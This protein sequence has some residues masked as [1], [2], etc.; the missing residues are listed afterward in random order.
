MLLAA[1]VVGPLLPQVC[2][3]TVSMCK[4]RKLFKFVSYFQHIGQDSH[5]LGWLL[6]FPG[7]S[8]NVQGFSDMASI[9][10][11]KWGEACC[12]LR[13]LSVGEEEEWK[14]LVPVSTCTFDKLAQHSLQ[15]FV[16]PLNHAV[17]LRMIWGGSYTLDTQQVIDFFQKL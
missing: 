15:G 5:L 17:N 4:F 9:E 8:Q 3:F 2:L 11:I 12:R 1:L 6:S 14:P 13:Y 7:L 16:K 10:D